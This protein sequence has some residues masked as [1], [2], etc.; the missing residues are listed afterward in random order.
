M[1]GGG[2]KHDEDFQCSSSYR[3]GGVVAVA[4]A[5]T[6]RVLPP[7]PPTPN[8]VT[9]PCAV[10]SADPSAGGDTPADA[11]IPVSSANRGAAT[12][13]AEEFS[14]RLRLDDIGDD[15]GDDTDENGGDEHDGNAAASP[16]GS[17]ASGF[18]DDAERVLESLTVRSKEK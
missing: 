2:E 14:S 13:L 18:G 11:E 1:L 7:L 15:D 17:F 5:A 6:H 4:A 16:A 9:G 8:S 10:S 12:V 3:R